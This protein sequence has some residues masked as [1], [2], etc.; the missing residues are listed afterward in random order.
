[1]ESLSVGTPGQSGGNAKARW[2]RAVVTRGAIGQSH[3]DMEVRWIGVVTATWR[4]SR[5]KSRC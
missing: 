3:G 1:V 4:R 2:I 5:S